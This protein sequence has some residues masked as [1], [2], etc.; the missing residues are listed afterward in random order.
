MYASIIKTENGIFSYNNGLCHGG[1]RPTLWLVRKDGQ[2]DTFKGE[3]IP[4]VV[5][6]VSRA[7]HQ[8]GKWSNTDYQL[9]VGSAVPV[10]LLGPLHGK[11][12]DQEATLDAAWSAF[13]ALVPHADRDSFEQAMLDDFPKA[14]ER[15]GRQAALPPLE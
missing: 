4:K 8:N 7:Y 5:S 6:V 15:M 2:I 10:H 12:W 1:R 14:C 11:V 13:V 9:Q 3:S